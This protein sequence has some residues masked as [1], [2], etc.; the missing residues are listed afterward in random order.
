MKEKGLPHRHGRIGALNKCDCP[1]QLGGMR[2]C[3]GRDPSLHYWALI[4]KWGGAGPETLQSPTLP[5]WRR[6]P[7]SC[8]INSRRGSRSRS[9]PCPNVVH[10]QI[11]IGALNKCDCPPQ[12][13]GMRDCKGRDPSLHYWEMGVMKEKGLPHRHGRIGALVMCDCQLQLGGM[14]DCKCR[15]PSLHYREMGTMKEK[16]L[17]KSLSFPHLRFQPWHYFSYHDSVF[18]SFDP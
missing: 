1:P 15:D 17:P 5:R 18:L 6:G 11:R 3:K 14:R 16:G 9:L 8:P 13:G 2:D 10:L 7:P 12:L 4:S